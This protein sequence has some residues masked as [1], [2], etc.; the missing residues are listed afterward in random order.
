MDFKR[1]K[2]RGISQKTRR[3]WYAENDSYRIIWRKEVCRVTVDPRFQ[4][5]VRTVVPGIFET[6]HTEIWDFV[7]PLK[8]LYRVQKAAETDCAQHLRLWTKVTE[9]TSM[10]AV[11][12]LLGYRPRAIPKWVIPEMD[13]RVLDM[14]LRP[15]I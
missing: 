10:K 13:R 3:L 15:S 9:C 14:I 12:E 6:G 5:C 11:Q 7:N 8:R 1:R 4:A 2:Q